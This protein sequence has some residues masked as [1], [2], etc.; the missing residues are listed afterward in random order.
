[1]ELVSN[2]GDM[3]RMEADGRADMGVLVE[4]Y[5]FDALSIGLGEG[6]RRGRGGA[7]RLS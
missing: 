6:G 1:M 2:P 7:Q 4:R 3:V 5:R